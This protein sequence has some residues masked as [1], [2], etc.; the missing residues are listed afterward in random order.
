MT[1]ARQPG[2]TPVLSHRLVLVLAATSGVAVANLYYAQPLLAEIARGLSV[3]AGTAGLLI[4]LSQAGYALGLLFVVPL[5]DLL[6][7]RRLVVAVLAVAALAMLGCAL[8]PDL[9]VLGAFLLLAGLSSVVAQ[10]LVPF[11]ATLAADAERGRV[12]GTVM[13]GLLLG[14]LLARTA[15]GLV[16][17][18]LG[19]RAVFGAGAGLMVVLIVVLRAELPAVAPAADLRYGA[20]L[21]SVV[22][23]LRDHATLRLRCALGALGFAAFSVFWTSL[24][25][26]LAGP[27]Y[28]YGVATI[29]LFG[30]AGAVGA[31]AAGR[32]GR[33]ADSGHAHTATAALAAVLAVSFLPTLLGAHHLGWLLAGVLLLDL[34]VQGLH[35]TNQSEVYRLDAQARS[36]LTTAYMTCYFL[37]GAAGSALGSVLWSA[38]GWGGVCSAGGALGLAAVALA[39]QTGR[40]ARRVPAV[41]R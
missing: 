34:G 25:F 4:T 27:P 38:F 40:V 39:S 7:R 20:A 31:L 3:G 28:H 19:W 36:R 29:G 35:I 24:A 9:P 10:V 26:L 23:L 30:L 32:A 1:P 22:G 2:E 6:E 17:Q 8:S 37:G 15:S 14:I 41:Q 5:G 33:L 12:V 13:T 21:R 16:G 11:A 18:W